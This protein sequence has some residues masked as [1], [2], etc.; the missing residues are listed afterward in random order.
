M[1]GCGEAD[2]PPVYLSA[3]MGDRAGG[4]F[5]A[6]GVLAAIVVRERTGQGQ[7]FTT[8]QLGAMV[9]LQ[10]ASVITAALTGHNM[11][12][13]PRE[14]ARNPLY[15]WYRCSDGRWIV[16]SMVIDAQTKWPLLCQAM[17]RP[18][19]ID[20][21]HFAT[22]DDRAEHCREL[23]AILD[24]VFVTRP[25]QQW[26]RRLRE[27]GDLV[28]T[29]VNSI[30]DL[31]SDPQVL[32]NDYLTDFER[33]VLGQSKQITHPI[34]FEKTPTS[35]RSAAPEL[36]EHTEQIL[37]ED[38]GLSWDQVERLREEAVI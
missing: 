18:D 14:E 25:C 20:H 6:M 11:R 31:V 22:W 21:P 8:S 15:N 33:P 29:R 38:L 2:W 34:I 32:E 1:L 16:L 10:A 3:G 19:L 30:V 23:V 37:L 26:E 17:D 5:L 27:A 24:E 7:Y 13:T 35:I 4:I 12:A 28:F 36:G 9:N